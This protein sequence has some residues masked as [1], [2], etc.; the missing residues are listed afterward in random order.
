VTLARRLVRSS[1]AIT[2]GYYAHFVPEAGSE[3]RTAID[4]LLGSGEIGR[5]AETPQILPKPV[6]G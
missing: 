4:G 1:P 2:L 5:P 6:E 3:G